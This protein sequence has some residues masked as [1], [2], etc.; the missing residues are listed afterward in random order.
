M[1]NAVHWSPIDPYIFA[2][3]SDDQTIKLWGPQDMEMAEVSGERDIK[4]TDHLA[5]SVNRQQN[6]FG[7]SEDSEED[8][9]DD[10]EESREDWYEEGSE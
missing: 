2:S 9:D 7:D 5:Q 3:A 10:N 8:D 4:K 1:A 6:G